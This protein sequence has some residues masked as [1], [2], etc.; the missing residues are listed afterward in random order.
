M[1]LRFYILLS[2]SIAVEWAL[3]TPAPPPPVS[4]WQAVL[5]LA[6]RQHP[7]STQAFVLCYTDMFPIRSAADAG[8]AVG[9]AFYILLSSSIALEWALL[10]PALSSE[11][12]TCKTVTCKTVAVERI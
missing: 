5:M 12:R 6:K 11:Y 1:G 7:P 2:P 8:Q 9:L 10:A 4:G 3:L